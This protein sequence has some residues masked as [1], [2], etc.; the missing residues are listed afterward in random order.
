[1]SEKVIQKYI[2]VDEIHTVA[3]REYGNPQGIPV[4]MLHGGPGGSINY[5]II[6]LIDL[7]F[8]HLFTIDQRGCGQSTPKGELRANTTE[9]LVNDIEKSAKQ[10]SLTNALFSVVHGEQF[11]A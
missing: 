9:H 4:L 5:Q 10:K 8:F 7:N 3:Y 11:S 2:K 1:M 6:E